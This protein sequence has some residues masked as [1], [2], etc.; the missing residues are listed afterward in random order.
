MA[1]AHDTIACL[2]L[3]RFPSLIRE[4][5]KPENTEL[6]DFHRRELGRRK[7]T[8]NAI[9][10][11]VKPTINKLSRLLPPAISCTAVHNDTSSATGPN[12]T[13]AI[14]PVNVSE[15]ALLALQTHLESTSSTEIDITLPPNYVFAISL[16]G[17]SALRDGTSL[18][19]EVLMAGMHVVLSRSSALLLHCCTTGNFAARKDEWGDVLN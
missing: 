4:Q 1:L 19:D 9:K 14:S 18:T 10:N 6:F 7:F 11:S 15:E 12:D 2:A 17:L 8:T 3:Q 13:S 5:C 16:N